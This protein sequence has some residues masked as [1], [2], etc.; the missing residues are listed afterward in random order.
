[1]ETKSTDTSPLAFYLKKNYPDV[2]HIWFNEYQLNLMKRLESFL[3]GKE[4]K[5]ERELVFIPRGG[6]ATSILEYYRTWIGELDFYCEIEI[7]E[8]HSN[9]PQ[10][11]II[12]IINKLNIIN[13]KG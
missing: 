7:K 4:L 3:L 2:F 5:K 9:V 8:H 10:G 6:G 13:L 1:M 12:E 11:C